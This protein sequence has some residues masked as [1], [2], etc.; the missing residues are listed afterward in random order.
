[1]IPNLMRGGSS[2]IDPPCGF[3][4]KKS[5]ALDEALFIIITPKEKNRKNRPLKR[6]LQFP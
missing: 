1:M 3:C 6:I 4:L 2:E 5:A